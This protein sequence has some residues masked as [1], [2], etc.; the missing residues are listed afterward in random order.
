M[1]LTALLISTALLASPVFATDL[2]AT[3]LQKLDDGL[4]SKTTGDPLKQQV[5]ELRTKA[6]QAR[7]TGDSD[8]CIASSTKALQLLEAPADNGSASDGAE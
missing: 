3:N 2:C 1:K 5:E 6:Q 8:G 7:D 4:T